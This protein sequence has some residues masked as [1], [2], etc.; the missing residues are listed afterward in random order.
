MRCRSIYAS[1]L[2]LFVCAVCTAA[3]AGTAAGP[4]TPV[5]TVNAH[6]QV[7]DGITC[8]RD[9]AEIAVHGFLKDPVGKIEI[10]RS[11]DPGDVKILEK[12]QIESALRSRQDLLASIEIRIPDRV[13]LKRAGQ[14]LTD[15]QVMDALESFLHRHFNSREFA[16]EKVR[17]T[18]ADMVPAGDLDLDFS[19]RVRP[20]GGRI[21]VSAEVRVDEDRC[22]RITVYGW[23]NVFDE[24]ICAATDLARGHEIDESECR[25]CRVNVSRNRGEWIRSV[26]DAAGRVLKR[27]IRAGEPILADQIEKAPVIRKGDLVK[28]IARKDRLKIIASGISKEDGCRN[29]A[30]RVENLSSGKLVRGLVTGKAQVEVIF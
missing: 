29:Q 6:A 10:T 20:D 30:I 1:Y 5:I 7:N 28:L 12:S 22:G 2:L 13:F 9:I 23:V 15:Q 27:D 11:P 16:L 14:K 25:P 8:L 24:L 4:G 17:I 21:A 18:G 26:D 19:G 3:A